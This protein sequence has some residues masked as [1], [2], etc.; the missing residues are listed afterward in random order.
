MFS[1]G[2]ALLDRVLYIVSYTRQG[3]VG[4]AFFFV[5]YMKKAGHAQRFRLAV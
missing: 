2:N 5:L 4:N 3:L 1:Y